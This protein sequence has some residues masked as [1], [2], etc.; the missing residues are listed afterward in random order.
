MTATDIEKFEKTKKEWREKEKPEYM[1]NRV[2]QDL[3]FDVE[4]YDLFQLVKDGRSFKKQTL[5]YKEKYTLSRVTLLAGNDMLIGLP[6]LIGSQT[7]INKKEQGQRQYDIDVTNTRSFNWHIEM[8]VPAGYTAAGFENIT[9]NV[10]NQ[11]ASFIST[12]KVEDGKILI[13]A[14]K[15]YKVA[16]MPANA[17][18]LLLEMLNAAYNFSQSKIVL[19]KQ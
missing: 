9:Y 12:G 13:D 4:K 2:E 14:T 8:L 1:K 16:K 19:I 18:S 15:T 11:Y 7:Q 10:D 5:E 6:S 17:W 3:N